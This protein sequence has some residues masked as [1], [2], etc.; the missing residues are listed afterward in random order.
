MDDQDKR[1]DFVHIGNILDNVLKSYHTEADSGLRH[2]WH[3]WDV[4]VG[5]TIAQ[6]A[7]P[8]AFKDN[9][10]IVHV[11]NSTW[12]HQLQFLKNDLISALNTAL[13][14]PLLTDIRFKIGPLE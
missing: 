6:N 14:Q 1:S 13:G 8:A 5:E 11:S 12:I 10:L 4:A 2:V 3:L 9:L 7:R